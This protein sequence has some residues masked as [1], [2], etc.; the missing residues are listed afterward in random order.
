V[1]QN[2][3]LPMLAVWHYA[4]VVGYDLDR[5]EIVLQSGGQP[6]EPMAL[7]TFEHTWA[8]SHHWAIAIL[9]PDRLPVTPQPLQIFAAATALERVDPSAARRTY[10]AITRKFPDFPEGWIGLGN[11]AFEQGDLAESAAA[12]RTATELDPGRADA[13]NNLATALAALGQVCAAGQA[14]RRAVSLGGPH[15]DQYRQTA[16]G[17]DASRCT[18]GLEI[19]GR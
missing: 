11:T 10:R 19:I 14:S 9:P 2:L 12:F 4:V 6:A 5:R 15:L 17:I 8:R 7:R 13:W 3:S 1:L 16:A 18:Q